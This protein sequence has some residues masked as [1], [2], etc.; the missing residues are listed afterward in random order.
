MTCLEAQSN[1]MEFIDKKLP[2]DK[3]TDFVRHMK[4]CPNCSEELE[5]YYTLIVGMRQLDNNLELSQNFKKD[6]NDELARLENKI[7]K[8]KRFKISTFSIVFAVFVVIMFLFYNRCLNK[9]YNIEQVM[10]KER[11]GET[12]FYDYFGEYIGICDENII[13][14]QKNIAKPAEETFYDKVHFYNLTHIK[15]EEKSDEGET[16]EGE[17]DEGGTWYE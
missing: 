8:V 2:D 4:Y 9:V 6:L 7:K 11:Q 17:T 13:E 16:D 14:Y 1:I 12:Y 3:I 10:L 5:I 15:P